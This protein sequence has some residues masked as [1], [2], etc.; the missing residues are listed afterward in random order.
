MNII[1][2][3]D[4]T[5]ANCTHRMKYRKGPEKNFPKFMDLCSEDTSIEPMIEL[6]NSLA[7]HDRIILTGRP[8]KWFHPTYTWLNSRLPGGVHNNIY[9]RPN[10]DF[11]PGV[12]VKQDLLN[13]IRSDYG[14]IDL[15]FEDIPE[16]A[17]MFVNNGITTLQV[18]NASLSN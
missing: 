16:I 15:A 3:I 7:N 14:P 2:D 9:M 6:Y 8:I 12:D 4:F 5:L 1:F 10:N 11:R 13:D 18:R 17:D